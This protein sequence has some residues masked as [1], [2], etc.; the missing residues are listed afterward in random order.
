EAINATAT[1]VPKS[2]ITVNRMTLSLVG[3]EN[4]Y[5]SSDDS[6][7]RHSYTHFDHPLGDVISQPQEL[8]AGVALSFPFQDTLPTP[9]PWSYWKSEYMDT[10][11][12]AR[13][14]GH[15]TVQGIV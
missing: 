6:S 9:I 3:M 1:F 8:Q 2:D 15:D 14:H 12:S 5:W 4:T 11:H 7:K 10:A 13:V